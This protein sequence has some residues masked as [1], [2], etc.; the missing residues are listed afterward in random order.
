VILRDDSAEHR[1]RHTHEDGGA[2]LTNRLD[3]EKHER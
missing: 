2:A 3:G 1:M